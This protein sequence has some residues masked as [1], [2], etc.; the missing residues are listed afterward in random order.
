M[1]HIRVRPTALILRDEHVLLVEYSDEAGLHYNLPGGGAEPGETLEE[2]V[3]R[4][5]F[6]ETQAQINVGSIA[7]VY[8]CAPHKQSGEYDT[9]KH[10]LNIIFECT[11]KEESHPRLPDRPDETQSGVRWIH[12]SELDNIILYPRIQSYIKNYLVNRRTVELINDYMLESY[13]RK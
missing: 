1:Y 12:L 2:G 11:L 9:T 3:K 8:E 13:S 10:S 7:F 4:E 5:V 6:E